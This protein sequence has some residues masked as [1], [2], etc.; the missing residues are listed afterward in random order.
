MD[1]VLEIHRD[2]QRTTDAPAGWRYAAVERDR[3]GDRFAPL[4]RPDRLIAVQD[5]LP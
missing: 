2:P 1:E 3:A 4:A 5:P